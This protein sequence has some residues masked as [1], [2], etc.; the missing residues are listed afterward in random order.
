MSFSRRV[1][2]LVKASD[3]PLLA[4]APTWERIPQSCIAKILNGYPWSSQHFNDMRG[5]PIIRIRDVTSG[6]TNTY[7]DGPIQE[8][9]WIENGDLIIGMDGD[10]NCRIWNGDRALLNQRVCKIIPDESKYS[11]RLLAYVLP[12]YLSLINEATHSI[13]VKH[14]SSKTIGEIPL[15]YPSIPEQHRI[16]TKLD[17]LTGCTARAREELGRIPKLIQ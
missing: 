17:S 14:L 1:A 4:C 12:G 13:T 9:Y 10:F 11:K 5:V 6:A 8:G 15:P 16:V 7:Y 3:S 2:D